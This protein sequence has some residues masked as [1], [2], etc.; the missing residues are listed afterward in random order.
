MSVRARLAIGAGLLVLTLAGAA[1]IIAVTQR[2]YLF[3]QIDAQLESLS[4]NAVAVLA[5]TTDRTGPPTG[6]PTGPQTGPPAVLNDV[7]VGI[8]E[9]DSSLTTVDAPTNDPDLRPNVDL[10]YPTEPATR[11]S[12]AGS[13][14]RMRVLTTPLGDGRHAVLAISTRAADETFGRLTLTLAA[15]GAAVLSVMALIWSWVIRLGLRPIM[16]MTEAADAITGGATDRRVPTRGTRTEADRLGSAL[17]TMIDATQA[18]ETRLRQFVAD[19]AH[20]LR[21]PLTTLQ[22]YSA[23]HARD[24]H[25]AGTPLGDSLRRI[26]S[27]AER[28][29]RIVD[30]L[31]LLANLDE[32]AELVR[33]P[34]DLGAIVRDQAAD[35][36]VV[37]PDRPLTLTVDNDAVV[38]GDPHRLAQAVAAFTANALRHTPAGTP[39]ELIAVKVPGRVR[40]EV[41]DRGPGIDPKHLPHLFDRFYRAD[42]GRTRKAGGSGLGLSIVAAIIEAH[43]GTCGASSSPDGSA[44]WFEVP[45]ANVG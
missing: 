21:T 27:E 45:V 12:A 8:I 13:A 23:L 4:G 20:E 43:N 29:T 5:R 6:S 37:V 9:L 32:A 30:D 31:Q 15:A 24:A 3:G 10:P 34:V 16:R 17:N 41:V 2:D 40:V 11:P 1:G 14:A 38:E 7:Y 33:T 44:F 26:H 35:I 36:A 25:L 22:G 39:L 18:S 28:M 19:A 42:A